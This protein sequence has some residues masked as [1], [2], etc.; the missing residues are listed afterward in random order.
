MTSTNT[1]RRLWLLP[2]LIAVGAT[3]ILVAVFFWGRSSGAAE[4]ES[5][6]DPEAVQQETQEVETVPDE[7]VEQVIRRDPDDP[8]AIGPAD[9]PVVLVMFSDYQCP[10]CS[11]WTA[12][13]LP[14]MQEFVDDGDLRIEWRDVNIYGDDSRRAAKASLAAANQDQFLA[15]HDRLFPDSDTLD[16]F[17]IEALTDIAEDVGL[18]LDEFEADM[19]SEDMDEVLDENEQLGQELGAYST[20]SFI[21]NDTPVVGAQPTDIFVDT[22]EDALAE[23]KE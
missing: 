13:T 6:A 2:T 14:A 22:V 5:Q 17:S 21:I 15:Y 23:A 10:F 8:L 19:D 3:I 9:A 18:D 1:S 20:P 7:I 11:S 12:D 4:A 16:D